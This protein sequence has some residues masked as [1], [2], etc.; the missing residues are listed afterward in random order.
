MSLCELLWHL[1]ATFRQRQR[2]PAEG[3]WFNFS[4]KVQ[5]AGQGSDVVLEVCIASEHNIVGIHADR[6]DRTGS[7]S[8]AGRAADNY[9]AIVKLVAKN[10][11]IS[12]GIGCRGNEPDLVEIG[13]GLVRQQQA[14]SP[15]RA[16]DVA[17]CARTQ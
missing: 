9:R 7:L 8:A 11:E 2:V 4:D 5:A 16:G 1:D 17:G 3:F 10:S 12:V 14:V 13:A 15:G 6:V